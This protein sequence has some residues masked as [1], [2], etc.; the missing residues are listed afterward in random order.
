M[1][2]RDNRPAAWVTCRLCP[3]CGWWSRGG[4]AAQNSRLRA[5][6]DCP[7]GE[8]DDPVEAERTAAGVQAIKD[9]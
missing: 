9:K 7:E 8:A 5:G 2:Q 3:H 6:R 4:L 1:T